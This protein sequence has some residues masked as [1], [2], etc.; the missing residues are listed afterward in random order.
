MEAQG[1]S[2][3]LDADKK[4]L[5][6]AL[7]AAKALLAD[8]NAT[9]AQLEQA[10]STVKKA[11]T[12]AKTNLKKAQEQAVK[13][14][15]AAE[16]AAAKKEAQKIPSAASVAKSILAQK[17]DKDP[18][19]STFAPLKLKNVKQAKKYNVLKWSKV[20]GASKYVVYGSKCG[21]KNKIKRIA[22]VKATSYKHKKLKK[23]TYYKYV[24][25]AV[26]NTVIGERAAAVSKMIHVATK[27]GK[28]GNSKK[29]AIKA[30]VGKK[31][32]KISKASIK[33]GKSLKL[34]AVLTPASKKL[35]VKKHV[36]VRYESSNKRIAT[37]SSKGKVK[38]KVKGSCTV[39]V[40]A[41]N[42][43]CKSL[44]VTVK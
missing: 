42:G 14:K 28:V 34:K 27:G 41:Q 39:Y 17:T 36:V 5:N 40:Y 11:A 8:E 10:L 20:A 30:K 24:V 13:A 15:A 19:G 29:L 44:K 2:Q 33:K 9:V 43:V 12:T 38:A 37:V 6:A 18:S 25:V 22:T 16:L 31:T 1:T 4:A 3:Y 26:K 32:K 7:A 23:G 21:K 35:E